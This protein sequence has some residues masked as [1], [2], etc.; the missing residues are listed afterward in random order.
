MPLVLMRNSTDCEIPVIA[1]ACD[2]TYEQAKAALSWRNLFGPL[3]NPVFGNPWNLYRALI[4]LGFWKKNITLN[5]LLAGRAE[6]GKTIVLIHNPKK[7]F[8][9]QHWVTW[10]GRCAD[11]YHLLAWGDST[12][13]VLATD[14]QMTDYYKKGWPPCAFQVY[15]ANALNLLFRRIES[16]IRGL[17]RYDKSNA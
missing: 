15:K 10:H 12:T 9:S 16:Y 5:D 7:P 17:F 2:V 1:N 3:E 14:Q 11:K 13:F 8:T 4:K 6:P